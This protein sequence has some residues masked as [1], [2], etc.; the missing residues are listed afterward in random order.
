MNYINTLEEIVNLYLANYPRFC[1]IIQQVVDLVECHLK[2]I[3]NIINVRSNFIII[4]KVEKWKLDFQKNLHCFLFRTMKNLKNKSLNEQNS[5]FIFFKD[6][7]DIFIRNISAS[8][9]ILAELEEQV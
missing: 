9:S 5:T 8:T 3:K 4:K 2:I 1:E 6:S 7:C